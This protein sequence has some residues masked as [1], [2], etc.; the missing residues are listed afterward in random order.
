MFCS[1]GREIA[2]GGAYPLPKSR[3]GLAEARGNR[4]HQEEEMRLTQGAWRQSLKDHPDRGAGHED[5]PDQIRS[6]RGR[7]T[8]SDL[9]AQLPDLRPQRSLDGVVDVVPLHHRCRKGFL[10]EG[11]AAQRV[12]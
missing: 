12:I 8:L 3:T 4:T 7:E 1:W 5:G 6:S 9:G 10:R 11:P 2:G